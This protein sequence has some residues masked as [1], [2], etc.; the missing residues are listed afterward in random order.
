MGDVRDRMKQDL[1]LKHYRPGTQSIYLSYARQF[2]AHFMRPPAELGREDVRIKSRILCNWR[3][4]GSP[5]I[6]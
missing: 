1:R 2:V 4:A 6:G 5:R 3:S